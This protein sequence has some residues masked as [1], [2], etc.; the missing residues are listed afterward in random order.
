[1]QI[2]LGNS[3]TGGDLYFGWQQR[4][5]ANVP[6]EKVFVT[7]KSGG[8][9]KA[10][11]DHTKG[12]V[13]DLT[14]LKTGWQQKETMLWQWNQSTSQMMASPGADWSRGFSVFVGLGK[15]ADGQPLN[16]L[17]MQSG[18]GVWD[19]LTHLAP[20]LAGAPSPTQVP[21]LKVAGVQDRSHNSRT[22]CYPLLTV[23]NWIEK[24]ASM[25]AP[26]PVIDTGVPVQPMPAPMPAMQQPAPMPATPQPI[27]QPATGDDADMFI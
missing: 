19:A 2:D 27:A 18:A 14:S 7:N 3:G 4:V 23:T 16:A 20:Q 25:S 24:P 21:I 5:T 6:Q 8:A 12:F 26:A 11:F 17:W 15:D 22:W 9:E 10:V 1:M 13:L